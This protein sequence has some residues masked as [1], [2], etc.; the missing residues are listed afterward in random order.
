M[1][2]FNRSP[3]ASRFPPFDPVREAGTRTGSAFSHRRAH[4]HLPLQC[5]GAFVDEG[6]VVAGDQG[7]R[8]KHGR[9]QAGSRFWVI[10]FGVTLQSVE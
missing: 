5:G 2:C 3:N 4:R 8:T 1:L 6:R 7:G 10:G 9:R